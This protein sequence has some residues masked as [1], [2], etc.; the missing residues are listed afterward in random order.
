M[1]MVHIWIV[2]VL[3][4]ATIIVLSM[5][6]VGESIILED[7]FT[8]RNDRPPDLTKWD[9]MNVGT[10]NRVS[11]DNNT[12]RITDEPGPLGYPGVVSREKY[13]TDNI[14]A[15]VDAM[16]YR[17]SI[18][19][20]TL[21]VRT[22]ISGVYQPAATIFYRSDWG[23]TLAVYAGT[24]HIYHYS[25]QR[26]LQTDFWY[27]F[28]LSIDFDAVEARIIERGTGKEVW[29]VSATTFNRLTGD[30]DVGLNNGGGD[31]AYDNFTLYDRNNVPPSWGSIP[32]LH[33]VEDVPFTY[34]FSRNVND[35]DTPLIDLYITSES[36]YVK[37]TDGLSVTFEFP[38]GVT[39]AEVTL[40]LV[41]GL[42][43]VSVNVTFTIRPVNDAPGHTIPK[44]HQAEED[45]P[46]TFNVTLWVRDIDNATADLYLLSDD[47]YVTTEGLEF[48]AIFPE[49]ILRHNVSL[50]LTD[51]LL[52]TSVDLEFTISPVDDT[53]EI[54][55]LDPITAIEDQLSV[56][57][58]T[59]HL[60][61]IDTPIEELSVV[62]R[63]RNCTVHGQEL[64]FLY[65]VG[66]VTEDVRVQVNDGHSMTEAILVVNVEERNDAPVVHTMS[67][68]GFRED[69]ADTVDLSPY[70]WDED[71]PLDQLSV[72]SDHPA[73]VD[74]T[75]FNITLLYTLWEAEH[76]V[77]F[78]VSDGYLSTPGSFLVQV[79]EVN[80]APTSIAIGGY[81]PP[82][83]IEV[84]EATTSWLPIVVEDEDDHNFRYSVES[85]WPGV[86]ALTNGTLKVT[87][88]KG[89]L[90]DFT[91]TVSAEDNDGASVSIDVTI[92]VLDVNDPPSL[93]LIRQP[94]N[95]TVVEE[96]TNVTFSVEVFDED[97]AHGQVLTVYWVSNLSGV[98]MTRTHTE[99]FL[100]V[101]NALPVGEHRITVRASD[102]EFE[103]EVWLDLTVIE[104]YVPPP[105]KDEGSFFTEPTGI[106]LILLIVI[107]V[108][109][110]VGLVMAR[111][112]RERGEEEPPSPPPAEGPISVVIQETSGARVETEVD[113]LAETAA[114]PE[115]APTP[116]PELEPELEPLEVPEP[117][118]EPSP[119]E[120]AARAHATQVREV[121]KALTQLPRGMPTALWGMDMAKLAK[122]IVDGPRRTAPDGTELVDIKGRWY[123]ADH[124]EVG[125][126][127]QER[128]DE[129]AAGKAPASDDERARKLEQLE[130]RLLEGK[131]SEETYQQLKKKYEQ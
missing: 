42:A 18:Q 109:L 66:G 61:D 101:T 40:V 117:A 93:P 35:P 127:L 75:G 14:T 74:V 107:L 39:S 22:N 25:N 1:K 71:T 70:I 15:T 114:V 2:V 85:L 86:V 62:V 56:F 105:P 80:D 112:R 11:L 54:D 16:A 36:K 58:L 88:E 60:Y 23:W 68:K 81:L 111:G 83:V 53:P 21:F 82:V 44:A 67:P 49:G 110:G 29:S 116:E 48:T 90:G 28:T 94:I 87:A 19:A 5:S 7:D 41:D 10:E 121:M 124:T 31:C 46:Y 27:V 24:S 129:K 125:T 30:N 113:V 84:Y 72:S 79:Q 38:N 106:A 4:C 108:I 77:G 45:V 34:D 89:E 97:T 57:N 104:R 99:G 91:A 103:R 52:Y 118:E 95:H 6:A 123:T 37:D 69:E 126:F 92:K 65:T 8:G 119:E 63:S 33:A 26:T 50:N 32:T 131:I 59:P 98:V 76:E 64:H 20:L 128:R 120:L 130:E 100:F 9:L 55:D 51:G 47:P 115:P 43:Q 73:V 17:D 78:A 12:L 102:G 13:G 3:A 96:G 122:V